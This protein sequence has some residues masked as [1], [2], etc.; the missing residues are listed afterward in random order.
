[1]KLISLA[2]WRRSFTLLEIRQDTELDDGT[3]TKLNL[4]VFALPPE[5]VYVPQNAQM[6]QSEK[7]M[8]GLTK[9]SS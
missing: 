5:N 9:T 4:S 1:M 8:N 3:R 2:A 6:S 7:R